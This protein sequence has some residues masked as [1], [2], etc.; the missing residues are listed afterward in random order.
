VIL[1][2]TLL[3]A[4][5]GDQHVWLGEQT[6]DASAS[7][8]RYEAES[9]ANTLTFPVEQVES[10]GYTPCPAGGVREGAN[11]ASGGMV[12][13][14]I[15][16]R[17]PCEPPTSYSSYD[18]CKNIGGGVE[19]NDVT[20]PSDGTFDVTWWYHCGADPDTPGQAN[21]YG[22][23]TCG[24]LDYQTGAGTGCRSQ[25]IDVNGVAMSVAVGGEIA[26]YYQFPCYGTAW[27]VLH[28]ATTALPLK[29]GSNRIYFHA[30]GATTLDAV[31][32]DAIDVQPAGA[33]VAPAPLW[34]KLVTP[35]VSGS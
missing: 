16:G 6:T 34:P 24:G 22:D 31:D 23:R 29:A 4:C 17:S 32:L 10:A 21:V 1:A 27:A 25:L 11:C 33:G 15:L 9:S 2:A 20:A 28:G 19:F 13:S 5:G 26:S 35:V 8:T 14:H 12:V 7:F 30:P 3:S 18:G